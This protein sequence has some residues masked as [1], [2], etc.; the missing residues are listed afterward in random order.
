MKCDVRTCSSEA[1]VFSSKAKNPKLNSDIHFCEIH[2][3]AGRLIG[4]VLTDKPKEK[5]QEEMDRL[6]DLNK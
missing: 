4:A 6:A 3:Q 5:I 1:T 2:A